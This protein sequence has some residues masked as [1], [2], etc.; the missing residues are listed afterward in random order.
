MGKFL[1][2]IG[3]FAKERINS[4]RIKA[5]PLSQKTLEAIYKTYFYSM[6]GFIDGSPSKWQVWGLNNLVYEGLTGTQDK[7]RVRGIVFNWRKQKLVLDDDKDWIVNELK[8][9][10]EESLKLHTK[11]VFLELMKDF[12]SKK[13]DADIEKKYKANK[14]RYK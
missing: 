2:K 3:E 14:G 10:F 11:K 13:L 7:A 9:F 4:S 8:P 5:Q 1:K 6:Q 12:D